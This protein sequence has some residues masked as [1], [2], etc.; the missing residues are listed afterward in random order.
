MSFRRKALGPAKDSPWLAILREGDG[1]LA[2]DVPIALSGLGAWLTFAAQPLLTLQAYAENTELAPP[3][4]AWE[5]ITSGAM[6][7]I[8]LAFM[9]A[10]YLWELIVLTAA[11]KE[12]Q[13]EKR[14]EARERAMILGKWAAALG[15]AEEELLTDHK[16]SSR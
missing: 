10:C 14:A 11:I 2:F 5:L 16:V 7:W 15:L 6:G 3:S 1:R 13:A 4:S 9:A 12:R 8:G